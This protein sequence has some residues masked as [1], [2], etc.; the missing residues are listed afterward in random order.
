MMRNSSCTEESRGPDIDVVKFGNTNPSTDKA[1]IVF[2]KRLPPGDCNSARDDAVR[3]EAATNRS[4]H[5]A[6]S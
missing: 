2:D 6:R 4:D 5:S 3:R 1:M